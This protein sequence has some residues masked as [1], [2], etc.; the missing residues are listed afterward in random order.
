MAWPEVTNR[1]A[2]YSVRALTRASVV[3]DGPVRALGSPPFSFR[4][5]WPASSSLYH[6]PSSHMSRGISVPRDDL[7]HGE[8]FLMLRQPQRIGGIVAG[9]NAPEAVGVRIIVKLAG[10][11]MHLGDEPARN[12]AGRRDE[13][14][15]TREQL[16]QFGQCLTLPKHRIQSTAPWCFSFRTSTTRRQSRSRLGCPRNDDG[17]VRAAGSS[18]RQ[19]ASPQEDGRPQPAQAAWR[20]ASRAK[21]AAPW[22]SSPVQS[23]VAL[24]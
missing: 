13:A 11:A 2:W 12:L 22:H 16:A 24:I 5:Q 3:S 19:R 14:G 8:R 15:I 18:N 7:A 9:Q 10:Q 1:S 20:R 6:R 21:N 17:I 4:V 23:R